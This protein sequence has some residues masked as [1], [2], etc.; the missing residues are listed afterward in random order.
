MLQG[1]GGLVRV[2]GVGSPDECDDESSDGY[3]P[4]WYDVPRATVLSAL[5]TPTP[6]AWHL[7]CPWFLAMTTCNVVRFGR[8]LAWLAMLRG[9]LRER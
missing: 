1:S 9:N 3:L 5:A 4:V 8:V 7:P 6:T 2:R